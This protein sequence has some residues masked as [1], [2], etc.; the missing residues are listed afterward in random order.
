MHRSKTA[1]LFDHLVVDCEE[2]RRDFEAERVS[3]SPIDD[4]L[5]FGGLRNR[6]IAR[7][8]SLENARRADSH[9]TM[10]R[11]CPSSAIRLSNGARMPAMGGSRITAARTAA[12]LSDFSP[13]QI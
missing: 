13:R 2:L 5:D 10:A 8:F 7:R 11:C 12:V 1:S 3:G 9:A 6:E 4:E